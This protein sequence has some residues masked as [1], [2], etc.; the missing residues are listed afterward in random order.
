MRYK[1]HEDEGDL[2]HVRAC[3]QQRLNSL[4]EAVSVKA[5]RVR[6][7]LLPCRFHYKMQNEERT[8]RFCKRC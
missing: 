3:P 6:N 5:A 7:V 4:R 2:Q 1:E 8:T